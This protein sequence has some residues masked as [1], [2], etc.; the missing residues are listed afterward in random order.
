MAKYYFAGTLKEIRALSKDQV[1]FEFIPDAEYTVKRKI[2]DK[3]IKSFVLQPETKGENG[4]VV[5]YESGVI[6]KVPRETQSY[7]SVGCHCEFQLCG[8]KTS[9]LLEVEIVGVKPSKFFV[10]AISKA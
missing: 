7:L 5:Q 10:V 9:A 4:F 3:E 1:E 2:G 8:K 6:F